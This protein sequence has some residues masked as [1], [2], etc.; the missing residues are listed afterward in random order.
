MHFEFVDMDNVKIRSMYSGLNNEKLEVVP[1]WHSEIEILLFQK[2]HCIQQ[3]DDK[4]V[5]TFPGDIVVISKNQLHS[6]YSYQEEPCQVLVIMADSGFIF[7]NETIAFQN[8]INDKNPKYT[9][10]KNCIEEIHRELTQKDKAYEY[11]AISSLYNFFSMLLRFS[12]YVSETTRYND[13]Y[14]NVLKNTFGLVQHSYSTEITLED[15]ARA[16]NLSVPHFCRLFKQM[17]GMTFKNYLQFF[18]INMAEKMLRLPKTVTEIAYEC[19]FN[20][21]T[22]FYRNFK[23]FKNYMP[24]E[25]RNSY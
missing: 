9:D 19:G 15:A 11:K 21:L 20:S 6:T 14:K 17:T 23:K 12:D 8:P 18:R 2:G 25:K 1:H 22:S 7:N 13:L 4:Y 5:I 10:M 24:S 16:S 3:I